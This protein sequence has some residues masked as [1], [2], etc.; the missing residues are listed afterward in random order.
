MKSS[1]VCGGVS[2][3]GAAAQR[4][5]LLWR[6]YRTFNVA[7]TTIPSAALGLVDLRQLALDYGELNNT[8]LT[9]DGMGWMVDDHSEQLESIRRGARDRREARLSACPIRVAQSAAW[10]CIRASGCSSF[11]FRPTALS[12]DRLWLLHK[13]RLC[14]RI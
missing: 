13:C 12:T 3:F 8:H 11:C 10:C 2:L 6:P 14:P 4:F 5:V 1:R 7:I 9:E